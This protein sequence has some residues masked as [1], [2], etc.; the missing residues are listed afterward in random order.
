MPGMPPPVLPGGHQQTFPAPPP[1]WNPL[2]WFS[3]AGSSIATW[4]GG[5]GGDI[6]SGIEGGFVA[7]LRS[8]FGWLVPYAEIAIGFLLLLWVFVYYF[9]DD[10]VSAIRILAMSGVF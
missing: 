9:K 3:D 2:D 10:I 6:A 4:L 5:L 8:V 7:I 1:T